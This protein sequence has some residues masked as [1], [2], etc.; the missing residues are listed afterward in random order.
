MDIPT[1]SR[2]RRKAD[3][4]SGGV[5]HRSSTRGHLHHQQ[6][7]THPCIQTHC[8]ADDTVDHR[9]SKRRPVCA[10]TND[11][12]ESNDGDGISQGTRIRLSEVC[13]CIQDSQPTTTGRSARGTQ[14]HELRGI[15]LNRVA[16]RTNN[17][18]EGWHYRIKRRAQK[19]CLPFYVLVILL[20]KEIT[21]IP[22]Q[23][24][25]ISEGKLRRYQRKTTRLLQCRI[26]KV[27]DSYNDGTTSVDRLLRKCG[28]IYNGQ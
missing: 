22:T 26:N 28:Q 14:G 1:W 12:G 3:P 17:D 16:V 25:M 8:R 4:S 2:K 23:L 6:Q 27:W 19:S 5:S 15:N 20:H 18:V 10:S 7:R 24:K 13:K 9:D 21:S 11:R